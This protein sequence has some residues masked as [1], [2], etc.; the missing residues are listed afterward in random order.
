MHD[1]TA[2]EFVDLLY[3]FFIASYR[4][5]PGF[6]RNTQL[7]FDLLNV[8]HWVLNMFQVDYRLDYLPCSLIVDMSCEVHVQKQRVQ[9]W[10]ALSTRVSFRLVKLGS[11][12]VHLDFGAELTSQPAL[13]PRQHVNTM[14]SSRWLK[15]SHQPRPLI[16]YLLFDSLTPFHQ[17]LIAGTR[18]V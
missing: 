11:L 17:A 14:P 16:R 6:T 15:A 12:H 8:S 5:P 7:P 10:I 9:R 18:L 1:L 4:R 13:P 2:E 3:T